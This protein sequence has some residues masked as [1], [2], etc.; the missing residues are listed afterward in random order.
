MG[1]SMIDNCLL[2]CAWLTFM[3]SG[4]L[5]M[6]GLVALVEWCREARYRHYIRRLRRQYGCAI[7]NRALPRFVTR[8]I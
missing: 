7:P 1:M 2:I 5:L 4:C 3:L 6:G 8:L